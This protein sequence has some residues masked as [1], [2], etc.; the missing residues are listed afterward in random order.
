MPWPAYLQR[1]IAFL[2][3]LLSW[4]SVLKLFKASSKK[5]FAPIWSLTK[6]LPKL[7]LLENTCFTLTHRC[8]CS[9]AAQ[10][11]LQAKGFWRGRQQLVPPRVHQLHQGQVRHLQG[12][13]L[14]LV[15]VGCTQSAGALTLADRKHN[16]LGLCRTPNSIDTTPVT[17]AVV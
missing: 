5:G 17:M 13:R 7:Q 14:R 3:S 2:G 15:A 1:L 12:A 8:S 10:P 11:S 6:A 4:L 16:A 9:P